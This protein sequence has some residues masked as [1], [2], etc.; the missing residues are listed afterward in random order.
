MATPELSKRQIEF[1]V[2]MF[3]IILGIMT[4]ITVVDI[5]TKTAIMEQATRLRLLIEGQANGQNASRT[6]ET[7]TSS[8]PI[9]DGSIPGDVLVFDNARLETGNAANGNSRAATNPRAKRRPN[10]G[11]TGDTPSV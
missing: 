1:W 11:S 8:D 9:D 6:N 2:I 7:G 3:L 10:S 5:S 4:L